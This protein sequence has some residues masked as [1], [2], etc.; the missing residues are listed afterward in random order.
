MFVRSD[1]NVNIPRTIQDPS[2]RYYMPLVKQKIIGRGINIRTEFLNLKDVA[3]ALFIDVE[4][5]LKFFGQEFG[6]K[7]TLKR[8]PKSDEISL[9]SINGKLDED[10][11]LKMLDKFI[12]MFILC[13]KD[14]TPEVVI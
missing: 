1:G 5:I 2:Y 8:D 3:K 6:S 13:E 11:V 9:T 12:D 10:D 14:N 4:Y 7:T